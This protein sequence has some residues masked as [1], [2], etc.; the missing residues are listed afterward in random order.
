ML[1]KFSKADAWYMHKINK[2]AEVDQRKQIYA[3]G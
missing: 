2:S 1:M 3:R